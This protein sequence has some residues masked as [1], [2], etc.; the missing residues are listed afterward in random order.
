MKLLKKKTSQGASDARC[1]TVLI[2]KCCISH[3]GSLSGS[4]MAGRS[5][6]LISSISVE[7]LASSCVTYNAEKSLHAISIMCHRVLFQSLICDLNPRPHVFTRL[8]RFHIHNLPL[9]NYHLWG[10]FHGSWNL[11]CLKFWYLNQHTAKKHNNQ[12]YQTR[13]VHKKISVAACRLG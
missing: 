13:C 6:L 8:I 9:T 11:Q 5:E 3:G 2:S 4:V 7:N 12:L 10:R 1:Q